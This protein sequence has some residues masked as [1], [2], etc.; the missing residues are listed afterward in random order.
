LDAAQALDLAL[1]SL[2]GLDLQDVEA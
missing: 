1:G 2:V